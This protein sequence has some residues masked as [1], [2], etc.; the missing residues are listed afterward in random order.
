[1]CVVGHVCKYKLHVIYNLSF[2]MLRMYVSRICVSLCFITP[3]TA[4]GGTIAAVVI[5]L[6]V[7][8]MAAV[9]AAVVIGII[10]WRRYTL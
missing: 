9:I 7:L 5:V 4:S 6:L 10:F 8:I 1:M 3:F 2:T